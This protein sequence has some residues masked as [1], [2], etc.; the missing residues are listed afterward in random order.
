VPIV[1]AAALVGV[2]L[3]VWHPF[4]AAVSGP[5]TAGALTPAVSAVAS[6]TLSA[7]PAR[8]VGQ[9]RT[10][11]PESFRGS[12]EKLEPRAAALRASLV[13]AAQCAPAE[14]I[15]RGAPVYSF[16]FQYA[17]PE[18]AAIAFRAYYNPGDLPDGDCA[19]QPAELTYARDG[20]TGTL[21]C[22]QDAAGYRVFA[23]TSD[24]LGIL[25]SVADQ[26]LSYAE[27]SRWWRQAGPLR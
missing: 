5:P 4:R 20:L 15:S 23:W 17:T 22:Y 19:T 3:V 9:L 16:Y 2:A 14:S 24:D 26:T 1:I 25:S 8:T 11:V 7:E 6:T 10:R 21:R 18:S 27:L 13:V 12:C